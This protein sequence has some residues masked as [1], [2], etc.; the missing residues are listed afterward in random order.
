MKL[1]C[2]VCEI[3]IEIPDK[4]KPGMRVTC[5]NCFAQLGLYKVKNEYY[6]G[7]ALCKDVVFDPTACSKC[8]RNREKKT[9]LEKGEL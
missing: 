7:C 1:T 4:A 8:E 6:L 3:Q 2:N 9:I 5:P